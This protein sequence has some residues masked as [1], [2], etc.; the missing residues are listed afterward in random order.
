M[1]PKKEVKA[2]I[3]TM[4]PERVFSRRVSYLWFLWWT[5]KPSVEYRPSLITIKISE[6][7]LKDGN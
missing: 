6:D 4:K 1:S 5:V 7:E 2:L 3:I